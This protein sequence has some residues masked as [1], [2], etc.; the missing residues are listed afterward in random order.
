MDMFELDAAQLDGG[1]DQN[2]VELLVVLVVNIAVALDGGNVGDLVDVGEQGGE[3]F[4][5]GARLDVLVEVASDDHAC[6]RVLLQDVPDKVLRCRVRL[7]G[8]KQLI[9]I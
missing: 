7:D 8:Y 4:V 2:M 3:G 6:E 1:R 5:Y 9:N